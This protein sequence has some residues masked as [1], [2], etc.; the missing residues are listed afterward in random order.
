VTAQVRV[1]RGTAGAQSPVRVLIPRGGAFSFHYDAAVPATALSDM[2]L[3]HSA[4]LSDGGEM[5]SVIEGD[6]LLHVTPVDFIG[7]SGRREK[8]KPLLDLT[9]SI[10]PKQR[11]GA[12]LVEEI[13]HSLSLAAGQTVVTGTTPLSLLAT[14]KTAVTA[15]S[16][17]ARSVLDRL[18]KEIDIALSWQ[19]FYDPG[20]RWYV[21]NIHAVRAAR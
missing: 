20:L 3:S 19:L 11:T 9:I 13:C 8:I 1:D 12:D 2:L 16:E 6:G 18:F 7:S 21:L 17:P 5:F 4:A 10:L 14:R 15:S